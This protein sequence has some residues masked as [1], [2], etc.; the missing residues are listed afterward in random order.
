MGVADGQAQDITMD[1]RDG[2]IDLLALNTQAENGSYKDITRECHKLAISTT[3]PR[4]RQKMRQPMQSYLTGNHNQVTYSAKSLIPSSP[5]QRRDNKS[6]KERGNS[7]NFTRASRANG[8][9]Q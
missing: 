7:V 8:I 2:T 1:D 5:N 3:T 4:R 6:R 9:V